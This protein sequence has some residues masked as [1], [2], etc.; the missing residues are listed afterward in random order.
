MLDAL[1]RNA[2][3]WAIKIVLTFIALTFV[4]W[5]IGTYQ[6]S[7]R[8][9]A[10]TVGGEKITLAELNET[11]TGMEKVYRDVYGPAFTPE[12]AKALDLR[13][14]AVESLIQ[15]TILL[16]EAKELGLAATD[17]EVQREIAATP[18]FQ[19]N[20]V[21]REDRYRSVL[22]YNRVTPGEYEAA[23]RQEIT[24]RKM[25]GLIAAGARV[26]E[27]EARDAFEL[28]GRKVKLLVVAADPQKSKDPAVT[29]DEIAARYERTKESY[30]IPARV[31]LRVARFDP[32]HFAKGIEPAEPEIRT[33]YEGNADKF[34][35]E[36]ERLVAKIE[37]PFGGGD[38]E[39]V[40]KKAAALAAEASKG[41]DAFEAAAKKAGRG[42]TGEA[43]LSRGAAR[44]EV[45]D[46]VFSAPVDTVVGPIE[47][48]GAFLVLRVNRIRFPEAP[49]LDRVRD[50]VVALLRREKGKDA[51]V[52][53]AYEAQ[54]KAAE[55]RDLRAACAPYGIVPAETG[56]LGAERGDGLVPPAVVQDALP[57][58]AGEVAPVKTVGDVHFVVQVI[59]REESRIPDLSA[60]ADRVRAAL[61][62]EK[63][64]E[65][66]KG[67]LSA[68]LS[69]AKTAA[70]L[71]KAAR[72]AGFS[73]STTS[74][75][76]P[77]SGPP[78]EPLAAAGD[79][80]R[81]ILALSPKAPVS[82]RVVEANG[83]FLG[84]AF[85]GERPADEAEWAQKKDAVIREL[86]ER[87][88]AMLLEAFLADRR[89]EAKVEINPEA[90]K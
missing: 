49:P 43:W 29:R 25:E 32:D 81:E 47:V 71:E 38:K 7:G 24:L 3:S 64:R 11:V 18:A 27:A 65:S 9:A 86:V 56:F 88:K 8:D 90:L 13:R 45:A 66:A 52:V 42:K 82:A 51:A 73:V 46:A 21:F 41:K 37:L 16:R 62:A 2:G 23:K 83:K 1:R 44:K 33:F 80:R 67:R 20:G 68:L 50:R 55:S 70:D 19:V 79:L 84:F 35:T 85:A 30:R 60:V 6:E 10:A 75:F 76:S 77:V 14:Q 36:E 48:P 5:G 72:A 53:K 28:A 31:R 63:K 4:W 15:R 74:W 34:R 61:A 59:A 12:M 39:A 26:S 58:P 57:L 69:G 78:P 22:Q 54:R 17:V 87:K 89:R 40:R